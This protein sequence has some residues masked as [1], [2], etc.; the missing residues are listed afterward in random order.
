M[1]SFLSIPREIRSERET[2]SH[3]PKAARR[4][5][6]CDLVLFPEPYL[7]SHAF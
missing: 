2:L 3:F 7:Q 5:A 6:T 4:R 1:L